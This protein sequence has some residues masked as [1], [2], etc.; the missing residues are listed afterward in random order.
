MAF[1]RKI[2]PGITKKNINNLS[3][4]I[5]PACLIVSVCARE[6]VKVLF[7]QGEFDQAAADITTIALQFY[8]LALPAMVLNNFISRI[9]H[10]LQRMR[11]KIW[12]T[13]QFLI[14]KGGLNFLLVGAWDLKGLAMA[15]TVAI[16]T[17]LFLSLWVLH[18]FQDGLRSRTLTMIILR[19]YALVGATWVFYRFSGVAAR[20][21]AWSATSGKL[22]SFLVA[23]VRG[24][25]V[26]VVFIVLYAGW[27]RVR[28]RR[29]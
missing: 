20:I 12:L 7:Q 5:L 26:L 27:S 25:L 8:M 11:D 14:T 2:T 6:I 15:T 22:E 9:F 28:A 23:C 21:D 18:R 29:G 16:N 1:H 19:D 3:R 13:L 10:A 4:V 24:G 17:H